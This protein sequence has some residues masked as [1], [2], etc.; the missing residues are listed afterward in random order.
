[1]ASEDQAKKEEIKL[2]PI[3]RLSFDSIERNTIQEKVA[4]EVESNPQKFLEAYRKLDNPL[5]INSF[6]GRY[7]GADLFK[8]TFEEY[9]ASKENR[10]LFNTPLHNSAAVLASAQLKAVINEKDSIERNEVVFLTGVPGAGKTSSI[11][12]GNEI[13]PSYKAVYEGQL[14]N[15][16]TTIPKIQA[17]LD[18]GLKPVIVVVHVKPE[19]ALD[20]TLTRFKETG[21]GASVNTMANIQGN[22]Y[23]GLSTVNKTFGNKI[24]LNILDLRDRL[25]PK[26]LKGWHNLDVLQSEGNYE[27]IK[28]TLTDRIEQ[29]REQGK[30]NEPA[31]RQAIGKAPDRA[32][33]RVD[34]R[35][36]ESTHQNGTGRGISQEGSQTSK[37][38]LSASSNPYTAGKSIA[39]A[40]AQSASIQKNATQKINSEASKTLEKAPARSR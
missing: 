22:L 8:E 7:I 29:Y 18:A 1:M 11:M 2:E 39:L 12:Q 24:E 38:G 6:N 34:A 13:K 30:I 27:K 9:R 17:V 26:H 31:Y 14:S 20:N 33:G 19:N 36:Y 35:N 23:D 3:R 25:Q 16:E 15:A 28:Q 21:R 40:Q 32:Y 4:R 10:N 37:L 5:G